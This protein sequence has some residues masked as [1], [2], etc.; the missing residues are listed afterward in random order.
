[1]P[2]REPAIGSEQEREPLLAGIE[3]TSKGQPTIPGI[4]QQVAQ[5]T[6][7]RLGK[8]AVQQLHT[9]AKLERNI[10]R[11][12]ELLSLARQLERATAHM[13]R[14]SL[15]KR[16]LSRGA[17]LP[18]V[19]RVLGHSRLSTTG[20]YLMPSEEEMRAAFGRAGI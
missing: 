10:A 5:R 14:H 13:L 19:Q 20:M 8:L 18:E 4:T 12:D 1:L 7:Q 11:S 3:V 2:G 6:A 16:I 17:Q 15:A 9:E